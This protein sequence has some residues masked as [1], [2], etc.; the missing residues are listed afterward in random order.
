MK[1]YSYTSA[2]LDVHGE[3]KWFTSITVRATTNRLSALT[4]T[5]L[6]LLRGHPQ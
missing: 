3:H 2:W 4:G 6:V 1:M 5:L